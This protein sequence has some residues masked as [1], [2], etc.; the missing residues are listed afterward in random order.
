LEQD[1]LEL[2]RRAAAGDRGAFHAIVDRHA[3]SLFRVARSLCRCNADA[4]DVVQDALLAAYRGMSGFDGRASLKTW[5]ARIVMKRSISAWRKNK[6]HRDP[7]PLGPA[8][9]TLGR[10]GRAGA[11]ESATAAIDQKLDLEAVL[12]SITA[13]YREIFVLREIQGLSYAEIAQTLD[14]PP[15]TVDSRL[16][17][18]RLELRK[19]LK[20]YR[21]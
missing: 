10:N 14:I 5:L 1:D 6:R 11:P 3:Q 9:D 21:P 13:E 2:A 15:G 4:E 12:P 20:A 19:K 8:H 17:R 7:A 18:A 16:H